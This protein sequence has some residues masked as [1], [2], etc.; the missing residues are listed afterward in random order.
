MLDELQRRWIAT[1]ARYGVEP[2]RA[3]AAFGVLRTAYGQPQRHYHTLAHLRQMFAVLDGP[4]PAASDPGAL[5][6]AVWL[7]DLVYDPA[8]HD[9]E[10]RSAR[11]AR[12]FYMILT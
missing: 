4:L 12:H 9:N 2:E 1:L 7:H 3:G 10:Q 6:L 8:R 5:E 11:S